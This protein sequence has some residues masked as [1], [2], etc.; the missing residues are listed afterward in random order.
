MKRKLSV[1]ATSDKTGKIKSGKRLVAVG[2][3]F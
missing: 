3:N 1:K 2:K